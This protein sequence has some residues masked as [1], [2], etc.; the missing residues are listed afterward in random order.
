MGDESG[1]KVHSLSK[2]LILLAL[3][4]II[5][6]P[7]FSKEPAKSR[8]KASE[9]LID[10]L[11]PLS[12]ESKS[13]PHFYWEN[14]K[15]KYEDSFDA[16]TGASL[17]SSTR[18]FS[19]LTKDSQ[20]KNTLPKAIKNL[21]FYGISQPSQVLKDNLTVQTHENGSLEI[22]FIHRGLVY[23]IHTEKDGLYDLSKNETC[24]C[25]ISSVIADNSKGLF[26]IKE[27]FL[28]EGS[29]EKTFS[30]LDWEKVK[31]NPDKAES[32]KNACKGSLNFS[33][34][35][36]NLVVKGKIIL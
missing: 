26:L 18:L 33:L 15:Q 8:A 19:E 24:T 17:Y 12:E 13:Q 23:K 20:K 6:C 34:S 4:V 3:S 10:F 5:I 14:N 1:V 27:E 29:S 7:S 22:T 31:L 28:K 2:K 11:C 21:F 30:N 35:E 36:N 32:E 9:I 16:V 25:E